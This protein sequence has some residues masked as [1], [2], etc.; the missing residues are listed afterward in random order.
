MKILNRLPFELGVWITALILLGMADLHDHGDAAHF[1]LCPL[2]G[3]GFSWCP[4]CGIGRAIA[5]LLQGD[6]SASLEQHWF[7]VPALLILGSRIV[8]LIRTSLNTHKMINLKY[9]EERYV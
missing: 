9:K 1:T 6:F 7:G 3:M 2:A 4:G 5:H 8:G